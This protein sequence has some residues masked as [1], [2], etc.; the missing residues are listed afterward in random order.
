MLA[1]GKA[2]RCDEQQH[3]D[4][5]WALRGAG[6]CGL[7]VVTRL[8]LRTVPAPDATSFELR[9]PPSAAAALVGAWQHWAPDAAEEVAASLIVTAAADPE[10]PV[11][12]KVFGAM[13]ASE[14]D[15][16]LTLDALV[17][18]AGL[19]PDSER[20]VH[21]PYRDT[22]RHLAED[23]EGPAEKPEPGHLYAKSEFFRAPLRA[24]A[25]ASLVGHLGADRVAGEARELD[26]T[27]WGGAYNR[28]R[29]D[30]TAFPHRSERFLLKHEVVVAADKA[31]TLTPPARDWLRRSWALAHGSETPGGAF[32]NFP[33]ADLGPWTA[34]TT[35]PTSTGCSASRRAT[36]DSGEAILAPSRGCSSVG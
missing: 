20:F 12:V 22:K 8:V 36:G 25:I 30:A 14:A 23:D 19:D 2:V 31:R 29:A 17:A 35:A 26:F 28:V 10:R 1:D 34:P 16:R 24:E 33:D 32:A 6:G 5:F 11:A 13:L 27:P 4:L 15:T 7:G 18:R 3:G 21:L 9:W